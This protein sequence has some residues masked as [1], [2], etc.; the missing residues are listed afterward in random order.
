ILLTSIL[1]LRADASDIIKADGYTTCAKSS[2]I[3]VSD[4]SLS[5]DRRNQSL[6]FAVA[7]SATTKTPILA[8]LKIEAY[9]VTA[10]RYSFNPC[11][12]K[13]QQL[14]PM[15]AGPFKEKGTVHIP[16]EV[17][18]KIPS[19]AWLVPDL[20]GLAQLSLHAQDGQEVACLQAKISNTETTRNSGARVATAG[21]ALTALAL[22]GVAS[23][24]GAGGAAAS[25]A[26][27]SAAGAPSFMAVLNFFMDVSWSGALSVD[28][29]GVYVAFTQ[30]FAWSNGFVVVAGMQ[31]AIDRFRGETGGNINKSS[32]DILMRQNL[33]R[34]SEL[35]KREEAS[36]VVN[37][38]QAY[39]E[40]IRVPSENTF[41]T[42]FI[43]FMSVLGALLAGCFLAKGVLELWSKGRKLPKV[44]ETF[45]LNFWTETAGLLVRSILIIY[46]TWTLLCLYQFK[47]GDSWAATILA[48]A[49]LT[50]F[51]AIL[52]FFTI[53]V[54]RIAQHAK[55]LGLGASRLYEDKPSL[56][57]YGFLYDQ[58]RKE[59]WWFFVPCILYSVAKAMFIALGDGHGL[60]QVIGQLACEVLMIVFLFATRA[61]DGK[62]AN[63]VNVSISVVRILTL[64]GTLIFVDVLGIADTTK[65]VA[66]VVM[67]ALQSILTAVLAVLLIYNAILPWIKQKKLKKNR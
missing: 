29:P 52:L 10:T 24:T 18:S 6:T 3:T 57:K 22:S 60:V 40:E 58:F 21:I 5:I 32:Y 54:T 20:Q 12:Y 41:M 27:G 26:A 13:I 53:Q 66:S 39:V 28:T 31:R 23:L 2:I 62:K 38:I 59:F 14:C 43:I 63:V 45:R 17:M 65:S 47:N 61:Y 25:G 30:N 55:K 36:K 42:M 64:V 15:Q 67:I 9:G 48:G 49:S 50:I 44:L 51:T 35:H 7:G 16:D 11:E 56:Q 19:A 8:E 37:G 1:L 34:G 46:G 33:I 4:F